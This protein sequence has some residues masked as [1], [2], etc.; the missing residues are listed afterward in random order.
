MRACKARMIFSRIV[1]SPTIPS[2]LRSSGHKAIPFFKR[3]Q[4]RKMIDLLAIQ[5]RACLDRACRCQ[6]SSSP[7]QC[8]RNPI[9]R[10]SQPLRCRGAPYQTVRAEPVARPALWLRA[11]VPS[12]AFVR[13]WFWLLTSASRSVRL[14]PNILAINSMRGNEAVS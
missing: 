4:R 3:F 8:V 14:R 6:K 2:A 10:Q 9:S 13:R 5:S 1:K 12:P 7:F 11:G